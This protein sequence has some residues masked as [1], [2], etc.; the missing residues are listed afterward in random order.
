MAETGAGWRGGGWADVGGQGGSVIGSRSPLAPPGRAGA[1]TRASLHSPPEARGQ[2]GPAA[3]ISGLDARPRRLPVPSASTAAALASNGSVATTGTP[4]A[5]ATSRAECVPSPTRT[6]PTRRT[7]PSTSASSSTR[8]L[9]LLTCRSVGRSTSATRRA[10]VSTGSGPPLASRRP[11]SAMTSAGWAASVAASTGQAGASAVPWRGS[12]IPASS[13]RPRSSS[14]SISCGHSAAAA[15]SG[16]CPDSMASASSPFL[17]GRCPANSPA[18]MS[19]PL[20]SHSATITCPGQP[21]DSVSAVV[22]TPGDPPGET[23][24]YRLTVRSGG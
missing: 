23:R 12:D 7:S 18:R 10:A 15:A 11:Q 5:L 24:A 1:V 19:P 2:A 3:R 21:S 8:A 20:G 14:S 16:L 6:R 4:R 17:A 9:A 22:V 13:S